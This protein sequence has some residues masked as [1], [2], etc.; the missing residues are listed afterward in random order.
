MRFNRFMTF[1]VLCMILGAAAYAQERYPYAALDPKQYDSSVD[2]RYNMFLGNWQDSMP[3]LMHG[4]IVFRDILTKLEGDDTLHPQKKSAVLQYTNA[5]SYA[6][7]Q[8]GA[9]AKSEEL[10]G[11]Q[12][13]FY[14]DAGVGVIRS[15]EESYDLKKGYV[16]I[17]TPKFD[18]TLEAT[19]DESL[20][21]Y[22][23]TEP[24]PD[25]FSPN[26]KLFVKNRFENRMGMSV[27]WSNIDRGIVSRRDG[28]ANYS[29][30]TFVTIDAHTMAQPHSHNPGVEECWIAVKGDIK[31]H[32]G[33]QLF[34]LPVGSAY[35]IPDNG[36]TAHANINMTD[37][38]VQ[39]IHMMKSLP[40]EAVMYSQL[41]PRQYD[42]AVDPAIDMFMGDW[43]Q[44]MPR[45]MHN[46]IVFRDILTALEGPDHL[47]PTRKGAVLLYA[48][49]IS[50]ATLEPG[51]LATPTEMDGIQQVFYVNSGEGVISSENKSV[52][53]QE[54]GS[55]IITPGLD[56]TLQASGDEILT[57]YVVTEKIPD[58]A[59]LNE[60]LYVTN[61]FENPTFMSVHWA[62]I[63]RRIISSRNGMRAYG[64]LTAVKLDA[65]TLAQPHSHGE[66]VEEIWLA[67]K[68]DISVQFGK[69]L[70]V[71]PV[72][73]AY[74][75]PANGRTA[76]ANIN[77]S[78]SP[79]NLMHMMKSIRR[80]ARR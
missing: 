12:Q 28:I 7:L 4:S 38:P 50:Y 57:M 29:G 77:A 75:I 51:A 18:F 45:L 58:G 6:V 9:T 73:S 34:D 78:D 31:L 36:I 27:H 43:R 55:F 10:N 16:F 72:G 52:Q 76:H 17:I 25:D 68:G 66:G 1:F 56:F 44:S 20:G 60:S 64:A 13:I 69:E 5:I 22:V 70:R 39:L 23:L 24:I 2:P 30:M 54:G 53:L 21:M 65:M 74:K 48:D 42:P 67:L 35:K 40:G 26:E 19:G 14:V 37:E 32:L 46:S 3:R 63:D 49:A 71:F 15:G 80:R 41:D 59:T 47:H 79:V 61:G 11:E 62:N 33:K 8:P